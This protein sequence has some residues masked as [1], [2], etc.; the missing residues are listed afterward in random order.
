MRKFLL[1]ISL[2]TFY[3][4]P[5]YAKDITILYT[6]DTNA[7]LY[8]CNCPIEPDGGVAR[9]AALIKELKK[10]DPQALVLDAGSFFAGGDMDQYSQGP[11]FDR[12]RTLVNLKAI[13]LIKYDALALGD[14]EFNF[15]KDFLVDNIKK[16]NL[17]FLSSNLKLEGTKPFVIKE[18]SGIK[19][20][21]IGVTNPQVAK[22]ISGLTIADLKTAVVSA[23]T[24]VKKQGASIIILLSTLDEAGNTAIANEVP[25]IDII[26]Q[27]GREKEEQAGKINN[28]LVLRPAWEGRRLSKV[29]I[30][31][32][33]NKVTNYKA[34]EIRLSDKV[35]DDPA[36]TAILPQCFQNANCR[37]KGFVGSCSNPGAKDARCEFKEPNKVSL[38]VITSKDCIVC[39]AGISEKIEFF[40]KQFAG[41]VPHYLYYPDKDAEKLIKDSNISSL[42][43]YLFGKEIEKEKDFAQLKNSFEVKG[44][45]CMLKP[46]LGG[47]SYFLNRKNIKDKF[48]LFISL[49]GKNTDQ[50]LV[51]VKELKPDV[52]FLVIEQEGKF[53]AF[54]GQ[55]E[56]EE[57]KRSL[58][59]Q[60]YYPEYFFDYMVCRVK[61]MSNPKPETCLAKFDVNKI[62]T[63]SKGSEGESLLKENIKLTRELQIMTGPV[64]LVDN[65]NIFIM[66]ESK[67]EELKKLIKR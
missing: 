16:N 4:S 67:E 48:D 14:D 19:V 21:I 46:E 27:K 10:Q 2:F 9:R 32:E 33:N 38:F 26:I 28:T 37:K 5:L 39:E 59:V 49:Y 60:K 63:C 57:S 8:P 64:Y 51:A 52:H 35:M 24:E 1:L 22:R 55:P 31:F 6:G 41:L 54:S 62:S 50:A 53:N 56:V 58:C 12:Q 25:G 34:E 23:I 7:M 3:L 13:E 42:P 29:V 47:I 43:V 44:D 30:S 20:G 17:N 15:G 11:D 40:K 65:Q 61:D 66:P 36:I 18:I 45:Y